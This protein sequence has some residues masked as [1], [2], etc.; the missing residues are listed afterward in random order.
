MN[1]LCRLRYRPDCAV[2]KYAIACDMRG[3]I[4]YQAF[5][6]WIPER[7][8]KAWC[9]PRC[10]ALVARRSPRAIPIQDGPGGAQLHGCLNGETG[11]LCQQAR[12]FLIFFPPLPLFLCVSFPLSSCLFLLFR[13]LTLTSEVLE[14][15]T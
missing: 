5:E 7:Q 3:V 9:H 8:N 1:R 13:T 4:G 14:T 11:P 6:L 2:L 12:S 15:E 10:D